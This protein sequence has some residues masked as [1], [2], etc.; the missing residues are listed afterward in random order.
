M[1]YT[2]RIVDAEIG[3]RLTSVG[4]VVIEGV[5]ACG[6]TVTARHHARSEMLLD[7]DPQAAPLMEVEPQL[8][9]EGDTPRLL[10]E[11]QTYP[12]IWN[13]VRRAVDDRDRPGQF[14]LTGSAIPA[15][16]AAR[17]TGAGR[18]AHVR[19]RPMS[20]AERGVSTAQV[21]L[22]AVMSGAQPG[23]ATP[24]P[25]LSLDDLIDEI[26]RGGWPGIRDRGVSEAQ[27]ANRDYLERIRRADVATV[28]GAVRD[29]QR[30]AAVIASLA[31]NVATTVTTTTL[32]TEAGVARETA[33]AYVNALTRLMVV[34]DQP[35][36]NTHLR[37]RHRL[38]ESPKRHFV[39]PSLA[40][41]ALRATPASLRADLNALGFLFESLVVRDLRVYAQPLGGEVF[42][43]RDQTG[44]EVDAIVDTGDG[45]AAFE[46]KLGMGGVDTA[47]ASLL[48]FR[49]RVDTS[50][51]GEPSALAVI[52]G[53]GPGY[54]RP[55]GVRV[56]PVGAF[57][58]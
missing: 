56:I 33:T 57:G 51:R 32:A 50:R 48:R 37:S 14:I 24:D 21:S 58:P 47:A 18:F 25:G 10:D 17:H 5:K 15:D 35:A 43:Y 1:D 22:A 20:L 3:A 30:L 12:Q 36:W 53:T 31:R 4:A 8:V 42:H 2:P 7:V 11:W 45:W 29:P 54:V 23:A 55:D 44:L 27:T 41:A 6:K 34:E 40:V 13:L 28:D 49:D 39:D 16:E 9:L 46:V 26:V 19:M 38:R 52:V